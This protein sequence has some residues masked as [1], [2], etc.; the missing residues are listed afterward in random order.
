[1]AKMKRNGEGS[2]ELDKYLANYLITL[3]EGEKL[4]NIRELAKNTGASIGSISRE[5]NLLEDSNAISIDRRGKLGSFLKRKSLSDLWNI[6]EDGPMVISLTMPSYPK[7]DG[8][9]TALYCL[10]NDAHVETYLIFIRG[11]Y[12]RIKALRNGHCH[13]AVM[14]VIAA[15]ELCGRNEEIILRL[16]P[17]SFLTDHQVFFKKSK[18]RQSENLRVGIEYD[19]FD[20]KF[21]T[22]H[23]F[24][25][26]PVEYHQGGRKIK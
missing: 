22:E 19:S 26:I 17:K 24:D 16:P 12:N 10:L 13:A 11:S 25:G 23:E 15:E 18:H 6:I 5:L 9:A 21:L 1:M 3:S 20:L 4:L 7:I 2:L 8:L 14:S